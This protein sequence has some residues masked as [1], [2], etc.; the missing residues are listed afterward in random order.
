MLH[1]RILVSSIHEKK[2]KKK[3]SPKNNKCKI[4]ASTWGVNF[5]FPDA[6]YM[7]QIFRIILR[8]L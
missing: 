4:S 5:E 8:I 6:S 3:Q 2:K 7:Y 1:C